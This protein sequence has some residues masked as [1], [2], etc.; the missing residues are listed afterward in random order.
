MFALVALCAVDVN[1]AVVRPVA[2]ALGDSFV[3]YRF[4]YSAIPGLPL[5]WGFWWSVGVEQQFPAEWAESLLDAQVAF[6]GLGQLRGFAF[7]S[8][9]GPVV[10]QGRVIG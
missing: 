3:C 7:A 1:K 6:P 10:G 4:A 5:G 9:V 2:A 8:P